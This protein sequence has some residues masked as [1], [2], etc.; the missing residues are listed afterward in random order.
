MQ[1]AAAVKVADDRKDAGPQP[2]VFDDGRCYPSKDPT[3]KEMHADSS[4]SQTESKNRPM[5]TVNKSEGD[6]AKKEASKKRA[7]DEGGA[8]IDDTMGVEAAAKEECKCVGPCKCGAA[9]KAGEECKCVGPCKCGAKDKKK[10]AAVAKKADEPP[11]PPPAEGAEPPMEEDAE[12]PMEEGVEPP[13]DMPP[14]E[15]AP[16]EDSAAEVMTD[17][18]KMLVEEKIEEAQE[19]ISAL[20]KEILEESTESE[21]LDYSKIFN[22]GEA[23][24]EMEGEEMAE[25]MPEE[26]MGEELPFPGEEDMEDK[27]AS[28]ANEGEKQADG[29]GE[30]YFAPSNAESME[31]SLDESQ[32]AS[33]EDFFSLR[34]SDSD[35]LR[36]LIAGEIHTAADVAGMKVVPSFTGEAAKH[37]ES[38][39]ATGETRDMENDHD[40]DLFAEAIESV[41]PEDGGFKRTKQDDT[42]V[43]ESPKSAAKKPAAPAIK[44]LKAVTAS[45][46]K[47]FDIASA[48]LGNDEY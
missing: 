40:A 39:T 42:N 9:K 22:E 46:S 44:K 17:E 47:P 33:M 31:A 48:L 20:E 25:G 32:F 36:A 5:D 11:M 26:G 30:E 10:E 19:A 8:E 43:L 24:G 34:G 37:F 16:A 12:P 29:N 3:P 35:P 15:E 1:K 28:L 38:N 7:D 18:K 23:E 6:K 21:E 13:M 27:A 14:A 4:A 45:A 41:S 2:A